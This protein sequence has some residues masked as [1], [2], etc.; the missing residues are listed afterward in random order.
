MA[1]I[2]RVVELELFIVGCSIIFGKA[3]VDVSKRMEVQRDWKSD[4]RK[5]FKS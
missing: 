2:L 1:A 3:V 5:A 4:K